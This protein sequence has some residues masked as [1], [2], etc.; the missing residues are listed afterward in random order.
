[1]IILTQSALEAQTA[2]SILPEVI[3]ASETPLP[4]A[5]STA[6]INAP[7][8][9]PD[10]VITITSI[11]ETGAGRAIVYW[12]A[13]GDFPAGYTVVWTTETRQPLLP[14]DDNTYTGDPNA[15][16]AMLSG[17][18]GYVYV[19]RVCR[20]T[21]GG[22]DVYSKAAF[23]AFNSY[24]PTPT[25]N[26]TK[27]AAAKTAIANIP[28]GGGGGGGG[29]AA[30][31]TV[32]KFAI[33]S[34][35]G[36]ADLKAHMVWT[37]DVSPSEGFR[38]YYS[39][40]NGEPKQGSDSYFVI[41]DGKTREA[42]VD[43]KTGTTY[44]YRICKIDDGACVAY[45]A[46]FKFTFP[47]TAPAATATPKPTVTQD[48]AEILIATISDT[49]VGKAV[50]TWGA[51]GKFPEGFRVVY[52]ASDNTPNL[53][54]TVV[55]V[56]DGAARSAEVSGIPNT[57]YYFR[58][59]KYVAGSCTVYSPVNTFKFAAPPEDAAFV[60]SVDGTVTDPGKVVLTWVPPASAPA[61]YLVLR[62]YPDIPVYPADVKQ[63][64]SDGSAVTYEMTGLKSGATFNFRLCSFDGFICT[65][66]SNT[67]S[68]L[69]P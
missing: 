64:I 26:W 61:G 1:A 56:S 63:T 31:P 14:A 27:T 15:R 65:A 9:T 54:D 35:D 44:Y 19:V 53:N 52:S 50:I 23:F 5:Q 58:V 20:T 17:L 42:Y 32:M 18:P 49:S 30:T 4:T 51:S 3:P 68:A 7:A 40:T 45:T 10:A 6:T 2:V 66:Y 25:I 12:D 8:A 37:S 39:T 60:L 62:D 41:Q 33:V 21:S 57:K 59:C 24:A 16:S 67:V 69:V 48:T 28:P 47:G 46:S 29:A 55:K 11:Q 43:G 38:I 34:M 13:I 36:G 22:C